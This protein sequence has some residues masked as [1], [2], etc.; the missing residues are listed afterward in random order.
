M[1]VIR[2]EF[3]AE[4]ELVIE[5]SGLVERFDMATE[6]EAEGWLVPT[7]P[8][9]KTMRKNRNLLAV[10]AIHAPVKLRRLESYKNIEG[11]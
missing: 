11:M 5:L 7:A 10:R 8:L 3:G 2:R 1:Q 9:K 6:H 4:P